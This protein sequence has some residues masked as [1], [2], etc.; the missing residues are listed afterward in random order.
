[1][2]GG[3]GRRCGERGA[4]RRRPGVL[5]W[6]W[7][8]PLL[9][10]G[11][12]P[13]SKAW[14]DCRVLDQDSGALVDLGISCQI[15]SH[16]RDEA[17]EPLQEEAWVPARPGLRPRGTGCPARKALQAAHYQVFISLRKQYGPR[18]QMT[19]PRPHIQSWG[20]GVRPQ[21]S[22]GHDGRGAARP[23]RGPGQWPG[24]PSFRVLRVEDLVNV[25]VC[26]LTICRAFCELFL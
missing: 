17:T 12:R 2:G 1:V 11:Y 13:P 20:V 23:R 26:G 24:T 3:H 6:P 4:G 14:Q 21:E 7:R 10:G 8:R 15:L 9:D 25:I 16:E 18:I 22:C 19:R 5:G